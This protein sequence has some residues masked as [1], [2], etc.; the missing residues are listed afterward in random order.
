M[1]IMTPAFYSVQ[2]VEVCKNEVH[3]QYMTSLSSIALLV[4]LGCR[5]DVLIS[6]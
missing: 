3:I 1:H 5:N 4:V 6:S 2:E